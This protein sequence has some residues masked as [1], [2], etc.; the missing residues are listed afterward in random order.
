MKTKKLLKLRPVFWSIIIFIAAQVLT[1]LVASHVNAFLVTYN[2][3]LP[4]QSAETV[5]FWP[6]TTTSASGVVTQT[7]PVSSLVPILLYFFAV[8]T[9]MAIVLFTIPLSAL[10]KVFKVIFAFLYCWSIFV[11]GIIWLPAIVS[12]VIAAAIAVLWF[13]NPRVWLHSAVMLLA[14]IALGEVFGRLIAPWTA[15]ILL[16]VLAIYDYLAVRFGFMLW[17]ADKLS[18]STTLPAFIIPYRPADWNAN[19]KKSEMP[20]LTNPKPDERKYSILGGGDIGFPVL[21]AA[22][23]YFT[24][25]LGDAVIVAAFAL[26]GLVGAYVIQ[27]K[28]AK[29]KAVPALPPIA[30]LS[31][32]G[33]ALVSFV[34][35]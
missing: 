14:M 29:G 3:T 23:V 6:G 2:I 30:V 9:V 21:L 4:V 33:L 18:E 7:Q 5:T 32:I 35:K 22:A 24:R 26:V 28:F 8:V 25:G 1:L 34:I 10:K 15:M 31:V 11:I 19:L 27:A 12:I 13:F 17:M 16:A 20:T